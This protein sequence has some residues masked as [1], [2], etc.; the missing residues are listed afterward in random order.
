M[1]TSRRLGSAAVTAGL[2]AAA[3]ALPA[4]QPVADAALHRNHSCSSGEADLAGVRGVPRRIVAAWAA[5]DAD[6][7]AAIFTQ[8]ASMIVSTPNGYLTSREE[9]RAYL[10]AGF[11]GPLKGVRA[12]ADIVDV[13]C[14]GPQT[15][16]VIVQGGLLFPG[17]TEVPQD[18]LGRSTM[19]VVRVGHEWQVAAYHNSRIVWSY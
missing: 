19:T 8:D 10:A 2:V 15:A 1:N 16:V 9:I 11:A 6:A 4:A 18:G 14:L 12:T 7:F 17:M 3:V 13:R 5:N